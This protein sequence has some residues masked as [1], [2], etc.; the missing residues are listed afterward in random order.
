V[1]SA[2][3]EHQVPPEAFFRVSPLHGGRLS[4]QIACQ[5]DVPADPENKLPQR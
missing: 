1:A 3:P 4:F 5:A 2:P